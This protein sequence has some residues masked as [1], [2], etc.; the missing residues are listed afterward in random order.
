[1]ELYR[2]RE[3][4]KVAVFVVGVFAL[5]IFANTVSGTTQT[6]ECADGKL[7]ANLTGWMIDN[8]MPRGTAEFSAADKNSLKVAVESVNFPDGTIL[9][10]FNGDDRL[11]N[12]PELKE[13][14]SEMTIPMSKALSEGAKIRVLREDRPIVSGNMACTKQ[15]SK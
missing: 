14:V 13:G 2:L 15:E 10:V 11:G 5:A 12:L 7:S 9:V 1:M 4:V 8:Q 3:R 6:A